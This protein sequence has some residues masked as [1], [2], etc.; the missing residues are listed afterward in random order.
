MAEAGAPLDKALKYT[1]NNEYESGD[2]RGGGRRHTEAQTA[3][4]ADR[5]QPRRWRRWWP[6]SSLCITPPM[7][8]SPMPA[9]TP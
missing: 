5:R 9:M 2:G 3:G 8:I 4:R 1:K 6:R 7:A